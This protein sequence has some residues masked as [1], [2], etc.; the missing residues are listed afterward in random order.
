MI[1]DYGDDTLVQQYI[2][3]PNSNITYG[4]WEKITYKID[5]HFKSYYI[6]LPYYID[7]NWTNDKLV[8]QLKRQMLYFSKLTHIKLL[9]KQ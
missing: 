2:D 6:L 5:N 8:F 4:Y 3:N 1:E 7:G 9:E